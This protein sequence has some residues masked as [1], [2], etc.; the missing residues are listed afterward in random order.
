MMQQQN[1]TQP[2]SVGPSSHLNA[3]H[4]QV[5]PN[6]QVVTA[7]LLNGLP[8]NQDSS[9]ASNNMIQPGPAQFLF[10]SSN[11]N[12]GV[13]PGPSTV[14]SAQALHASTFSPAGLV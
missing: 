14:S 2:H 1:Q 10:N 4:H 12:H 13:S 3:V 8:H 9:L 7:S 6:Q 11:T 5:T